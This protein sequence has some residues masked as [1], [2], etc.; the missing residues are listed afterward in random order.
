[1]KIRSE[2]SVCHR[3]R[4]S[5]MRTSVVSHFAAQLLPAL[6]RSSVW[7]CAVLLSALS[8]LCYSQQ[9]QNAVYNTGG[10]APT[11]SPSFF[12]ATQFPAADPCLQIQSAFGALPSSGGTVDARGL[13]TGTPLTCSVNPIP[14]GAKGRLLLGSGI[15]LAQ[16]P[17]VIQGTNANVNIIGT[18]PSGNTGNNT[19]IQACASGQTGCGGVVFPSGKAVIQ[20]GTSSSTVFRSTVKDLAVDCQDVPGVSG[21]QVIAAQEETVFDLVRATGCRVA[22]FDIGAGD[23]K[24]MNGAALSNF[25]A[26]YTNGAGCPSVTNGT[27]VS[28]TLDGSG[29]VTATYGVA[30]IPALVPGYEVVVASAGTSN[31]NGT[32]RVNSVN[33]GL[34]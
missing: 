26:N 14:S 15:Y 34:S 16:V 5:L 7:R 32:Y 12:D 29:N 11:P 30:S 17:W 18:G 8:G 9:G 13:T 28:A 6:Q 2:K 33:T 19:I 21:F 10:S 4:S 3:R 27:I 24:T 25:E 31:F 23:S 22:S 20:M 1:M